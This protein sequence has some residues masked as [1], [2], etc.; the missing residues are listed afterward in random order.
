MYYMG[1][2]HCGISSKQKSLVINY[3]YYKIIL[4]KIHKEKTDIYNLM[5][6]YAILK[7]GTSTIRAI[8]Q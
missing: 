2:T 7:K 6:I 1:Y 5:N 3:F 4:Y 8:Q